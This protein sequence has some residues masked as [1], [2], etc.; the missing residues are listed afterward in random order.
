MSL[1]LKLSLILLACS[2]IVFAQGAGEKNNPLQGLLIT[3]LVAVAGYLAKSFYDLLMEKRK[4][5]IQNIEDKLK[6]FYWPI[7]IRLE[8]D[9]AIWNTILSKRD[10]KDSIQYR[11]ANHVEKSNILKTHAE[12]LK[13]INDYTYLADP[14]DELIKE[15]KGYVRNVTILK[16]LRDAGEERMFPLELGAAYPKNFYRLIKD[17][18]EYYQ[19]KLN[20]LPV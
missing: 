4:R 11:I 14:D 20:A 16:A 3:T 10:D 13:I 7:L 8:M 9:N 19:N 15:I 12:V 17:K 18:T 2:L 6:L 1:K 5:K